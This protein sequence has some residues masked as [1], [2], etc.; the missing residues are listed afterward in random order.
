MDLTIQ[1]RRV[2]NYSNTEIPGD[3]E[4]AQSETFENEETMQINE[5][6]EPSPAESRPEIQGNNHD[7]QSNEP[8]PTENPPEEQNI[9]SETASAQSFLFR[10]QETIITPDDAKLFLCEEEEDSKEIKGENSLKITPAKNENLKRSRTAPPR[11]L[12][13]MEEFRASM[14]FLKMEAVV[15][16]AT[17]ILLK[18]DGNFDL[19]SMDGYNTCKTYL[20]EIETLICSFKVKTV[21]RKYRNKFSHSYKILF[22]DGHLCYLPEILDSAQERFPYILVN[23]EKYIFSPNVLNAGEKLAGSLTN[24]RNSI[25]EIYNRYFIL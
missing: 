25:R 23:S 1:V 6:P 18:S 21:S 19:D 15:N 3:S 2:S 9:P 12:T 5:A 4:D 11:K 7:T 24:L 17:G 8:E 22:Q 14:E 16:S 13:E 10:Q 20:N